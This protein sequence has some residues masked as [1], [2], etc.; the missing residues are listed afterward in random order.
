MSKTKQILYSDLLPSGQD[1]PILHLSCIAPQKACSQGSPTTKSY[2]FGHLGIKSFID[3]ASSVKMAGDCYFLALSLTLTCLCPEKTQVK[4]LANVQ[5]TWPRTH[6]ASTKPSTHKNCKLQS[7]LNWPTSN[8]TLW[9]ERIK[10]TAKA[11][12]LQMNKDIKIFLE[13]HVHDNF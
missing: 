9:L 2:L 4:N 8:K 11:I 6:I 10:L 3:Q 7:D 12:N 1:G 13:L 5:S